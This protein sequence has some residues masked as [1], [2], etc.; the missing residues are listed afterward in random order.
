[1][2]PLSAV[3]LLPV[4]DPL[5]HAARRASGATAL[6]ESP[7]SGAGRR[8]SYGE[9]DQAVNGV[10]RELARRVVGRE[11]AVS[12]SLA[13]SPEAVAVCHAAWRLGA[14][15][16]LFH[17]D[18]TPH[19]AEGARAAVGPIVVEVGDRDEVAGWM[20]ATGGAGEPR[21]TRSRGT[22]D[23]AAFVLTSGSTGAPRA[24]ALTHANLYASAEAV[25]ERLELRETD[26]WLTSLSLA[27]VGG[28][29]LVHRAAVVGCQ[30]VT[31][32][33]FA[34]EE[35]ASLIDD[36]RVTHL[37]VVPVTL[38]R[39]LESRG[40]RLAPSTLRCVLL[41]GA[42]A[43][44]LLVERAVA[45]GYPVALTYGLTEATSQVATAP[46]D[47]VRAKP[48]AVGRPLPGV[49]VRIGDGGEILVRGPTVAA[50]AGWLA[51]GDLGQVDADGDL[52]VVGRASDRIVTGGVT[53][54]PA[55]VEAVL[56]RHAE[57]AEVA[58]IGEPDETWG[59]RIVAVLVP[60]DPLRPPSLEDLVEF[61]RYSLG[62][63][64][65]PRGLRLVDALPRIA[66]GKVDRARLRPS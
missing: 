53:V 2:D 55:E 7:L 49:E 40:D 54:E 25:I 23:V 61:C 35:V 65:R 47:R 6:T 14:R 8:W 63:A 1:V 34:A 18:W 43:P 11:S 16:V 30:V 21:A 60:R 64:K 17:P 5:R 37:S 19:E 27:H 4:V 31:I 39:L 44:P 3:D 48:G 66:N 36:G 59:E 22:S 52:W 12:L 29:A 24:V 20:T 56:Q 10:A 50:G 13:A 57:V 28:L 58:V 46:P 45:L 15:L 9:L 51:T 42:A 62:S 33:R 32:P 38:A 41:G 26:S